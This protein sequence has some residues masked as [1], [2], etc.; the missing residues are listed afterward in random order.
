MYVADKAKHRVKVWTKTGTFVGTFG[1][2]GH[3]NGEFEFPMGLATLGE[4]R[5]L[6]LDAGGER[7]QEVSFTG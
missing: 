7:I 3:G 4:G 2:T 6:V 5:I 1:A